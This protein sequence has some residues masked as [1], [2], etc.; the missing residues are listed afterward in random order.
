M[1]VASKPSSER[2]SHNQFLRF[3]T[4]H[5]YD[6]DATLRLV[7]ALAV[8]GVVT[9]HVGCINTDKA[10]TRRNRYRNAYILDLTFLRH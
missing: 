6:V 3:S 1:A 5:A 10:D 9:F 2:L 4:L 7:D 8:E